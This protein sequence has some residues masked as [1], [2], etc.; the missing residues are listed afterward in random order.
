MTRTKYELDNKIKETVRDIELWQ[1][2][3][4]QVTVNKG[5]L[6]VSLRIG[7]KRRGYIFHGQGKLILDTIIETK[8]GAVGK[9]VQEE[10]SKPFLMIGQADE[11]EECLANASDEEISRLGYE[12]QEEF[13]ERAGDLSHRFFGGRVHNNLDFDKSEGTIFAFQNKTL[14]LNILISEESELVYKTSNMVFV[15]N[16]QEVVLK[17]PD[18]TVCSS[19]GKSVIIRNG[20]SLIIEE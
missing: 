14:K 18:A 15:S 10:L 5:T 17:S 13:A 4:G 20:K 8:E 9:S 12:S 16:N 3:K 6:A 7:G 19:N 2:D 11:T 1:S